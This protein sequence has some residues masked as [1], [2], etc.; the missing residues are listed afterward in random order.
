MRFTNLKLIDMHLCGPIK[1]ETLGGSMEALIAEYSRV[2]WV[3]ML[4]R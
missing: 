4:K 1:L 3:A 2:M